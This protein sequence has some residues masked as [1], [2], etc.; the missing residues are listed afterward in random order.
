M[1][2]LCTAAPQHCTTPPAGKLIR[3]FTC[4]ILSIY[5]SNNARHSIWGV[6]I[7]LLFY[8]HLQKWEFFALASTIGSLLIMVGW[9]WFVCRLHSVNRDSPSRHQQS[10]SDSPADITTSLQHERFKHLLGSAHF[11]PRFEI[12]SQKVNCI[13]FLKLETEAPLLL[14]L[15]P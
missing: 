12:L 14:C 4:R 7:N 3:T 6:R 13:V 15:C 8:K 5:L 11:L 9:W 2:T 1:S 10:Q